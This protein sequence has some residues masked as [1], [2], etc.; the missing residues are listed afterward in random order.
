MG[1][2]WA[3]R[4][5]STEREV[6]IKLLLGSSKNK[7]FR[8]RLL[9]EAR[10]SG[11]IAHRNVVEIYDVDESEQGHPFL[12]MQMLR[13]ETLAALLKR[14]GPL[15]P[16]TA[17][18]I[19]VDI[20]RALI[21][22]HAA[23]VVHRDLKPENVFLHQESDGFMVV[24]VVDFGVSKLLDSDEP[25]TS[26]TGVPVG[27][28]AYM[29]PEQARGARD[30]G[31]PSDMW[32][33][34]VMLFE[35]LAGQRPFT[36][37]TSNDVVG[38]VTRG[39]IPRLA[40]VLPGIDP[41]MDEMVARCLDRTPSHRPTAVDALAALEPA[42]PPGELSS[43]QAF[44]LPPPSKP[45]EAGAPSQTVQT[46][47]EGEPSARTST[48][49]TPASMASSSTQPPGPTRSGYA[50]TEATP[51]EPSAPDKRKPLGAIL[52]F[53][54]AVL[55]LGVA[56]GRRSP[57]SAPDAGPL[58]PAP[59]ATLPPAV[60]PSG[61]PI[62]AATGKAAAPAAGGA[63]APSAGGV[64]GQASAAGGVAGQ[65]GAAGAV[66]GKTP[67]AH[68]TRINLPPGCPPGCKSLRG[69]CVDGL[70]LPCKR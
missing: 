45:A 40:S 14:V 19:T 61:G 52:G 44:Q 57:P 32:A 53:G 30:V 13:G 47:P 34:G 69:T 70:E 21:A 6:A 22:A 31:P 33:V 60:G 64:A 37:A 62:E 11:R 50:P 24:K 5:E 20:L 68:K 27:S 7:D 10:A 18:A 43:Y 2:V 1:V 63:A 29:S 8:D 35:L 3:A 15:T 28:P 67:A 66:G 16:P 46:A 39:P 23:G 9:R 49:L 36:G 59:S 51:T 26:V 54:L 48:F 17:A 58:P 56:L 25:T 38:R 12:V 41:G 42:V 65:A 55:L 4:N